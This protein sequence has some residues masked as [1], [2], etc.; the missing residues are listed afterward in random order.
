MRRLKSTSRRGV[1]RSFY[2]NNAR[3]CSTGPCTDAYRSTTSHATGNHASPRTPAERVDVRLVA[4]PSASAAAFF[5]RP[6]RDSGSVGRT[7]AASNT[8]D[9]CL[10]SPER[11]PPPT[12]TSSEGGTSPARS[13]ATRRLQRERRALHRRACHARVRQR[14]RPEAEQ[15]ARGLRPVGHA[16]PPGKAGSARRRIRGTR[17]RARR[18][19]RATP[20]RRSWPTRAPPRRRAQ[21]SAQ[22]GQV[23]AERVA[24]GR[25]GARD[26]EHRDVAGTE[27]RARRAQR[28]HQAPGTRGWTP[29]AAQALSLDPVATRHPAGNPADTVT[30][31]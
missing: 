18:A 25:D 9:D 1:K 23:L 28:D 7:T 16:P 21:L 2:P 4:A 19:R 22:Q 12:Q 8:R 15:R 31:G 17:A 30:R 29:I 3:D 10:Q 24:E 20:P 14:P 26:A 27:Q 13:N 5:A 6:A 11:E